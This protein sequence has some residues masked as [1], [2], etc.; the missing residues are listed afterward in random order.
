MPGARQGTW[1]GLVK[2]QNGGSPTSTGGSDTAACAPT[3][4]VNVRRSFVVRQPQRFQQL[5]R[6]L[7]TPG[8]ADQCDARIVPDVAYLL[9]RYNL[10]A[11]DCRATGHA[12]HGDGLSIDIVP[13]EDQFPQVGDTSNINAWKRLE[14]GI[15]TLGWKPSCAANGC[16]GTNAPAI[17][18]IF[19]NGF[20]NHGDPQGFSGPCGCPHVHIR[21]SSQPP[22]G[23]VPNL[24]PPATA[25]RVYTPPAGATATS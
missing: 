25:V 5:P 2:V 11:H 14:T 20:T 21:W 17:Y 12:T 10:R 23:G 4:D 1:S 6:Q 9:R 18:A 15:R 16:I 19:Y 7:I 22:T 3:G 24:A 13:A 8:Y